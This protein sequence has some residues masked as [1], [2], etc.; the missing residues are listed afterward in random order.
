MLMRD[1]V[2]QRWPGS[3]CRRPRPAGT[4]NP[5]AS[6]APHEE[7]GARSGSVIHPCRPAAVS[8]ATP[9][10][11]LG[12][13]MLSRV[14]RA[15]DRPTSTTSSSA[16]APRDACSPTGSAR[17]R[18]VRVLLVE[19]GGPDANPLDQ[20]AGQMDVAASRPTI[21]WNYATE[22]VPGLEGRRLKW[23]MG[24]VVRRLDARSTRWPTCAAITRCFDQWA[25]AG[26]PAWS[27][28]EARAGLQSARGQLARRLRSIAGAGGP[29]RRVGHD[30]STCGAPGVPRG[31]ARTR[32]RREPTCGISTAPVRS[33]GAGFYQKTIRAGSGSPRRPRFSRPALARPNLT[34]WPTAQVLRLTCSTGGE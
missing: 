11:C 10:G 18:S 28:R 22:P 1:S 23:P 34:V 21:D 20:R 7:K 8:F 9:P 2:G 25:A 27:F 30:R 3:T 13:A 24:K 6:A 17:M 26:G 15:Q 29:M 12:A 32:V 31:G 33:G 19:A 16:P 4:C 14:T 5:I